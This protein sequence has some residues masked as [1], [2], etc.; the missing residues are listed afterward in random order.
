MPG[1]GDLSGH[2][3]GMVEDVGSRK[4]EFDWGNVIERRREPREPEETVAG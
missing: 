2:G 4:G 1:E 3:V